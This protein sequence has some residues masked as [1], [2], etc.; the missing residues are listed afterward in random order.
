M[1]RST[2][3]MLQLRNLDSSMQ[4]MCENGD[5]IK[6]S[7]LCVKVTIKREN[8]SRVGVTNQRTMT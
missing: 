4:S 7:S 5:K 6:I 8:V 2:E 3:T 1:P